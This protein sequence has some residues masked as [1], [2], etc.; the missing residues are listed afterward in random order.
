MWTFVTSSISKVIPHCLVWVGCSFFPFWRLWVSSSGLELCSGSSPC[1]CCSQARSFPHF[2]TGGMSICTMF[3][4]STLYFSYWR[5]GRTVTEGWWMSQCLEKRHKKCLC[6]T[7]GYF[8]IDMNSFS[9]KIM[10]C[11]EQLCLG[12]WLG[13]FRSLIMR[14]YDFF[15][16]T[17]K[18][19]FC[20][21]KTKIWKRN[22]PNNTSPT[23]QKT[24]YGTFCFLGLFALQI[25]F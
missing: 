5:W 11:Y 7:A 20:F 15:L 18:Q 16:L 3:A 2:H 10:R 14:E 22:K 8:L 9:W 23:P 21:W 25:C 4:P 12:T 17:E 24:L 6:F 1:H 13:F 19:I